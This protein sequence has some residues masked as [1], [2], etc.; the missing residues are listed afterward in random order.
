MLHYI[1]KLSTSLWQP[2]VWVALLLAAGVL[3]LFARGKRGRQWGRRLCAG[4]LALLLAL[5]WYP[6][7]DALLRG[8]EDQHSA[9]TGD[10]SGYHGMVVLGGA[11]GRDDGRGH[12][13]LALGAAAERVVDPV[14][15][16]RRYPHLRVLFTGG[17]GTVFGPVRRAEADIA[18]EFFDR[19]GTEISQFVIETKSRNTYENAVLSRE[20]PGV[21]AGKPWLLVTSA[22]HMPRALATFRK[23]GWNVTA[24]PVDYET[25]AGGSW[26]GYG[27]HDGV[28]TWQMA[29]R[30]YLGIAFYRLTGRL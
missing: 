29:I 27:L 28:N 3:L 21:D 16:L 15:T 11:F 18:R 1:S 19:M 17:D 26:F 12:R 22:A 14:M 6:L 2:L 4:A 30:E 8:L 24:Y 25:L 5:G 7:P 9:P 23:A 10:L 20:V 13:P